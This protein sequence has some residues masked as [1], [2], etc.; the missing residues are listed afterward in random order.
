MNLL[1]LDRFLLPA[2]LAFSVAS[3]V[4]ADEFPQSY[5]RN[6]LTQ[7]ATEVSVDTSHLK[8]GEFMSIRY[9]GRPVYIYRR[10]ASDIKS[11]ESAQEKQFADPD[12][13]GFRASVLREYGSSS[14]AVWARLLFLAQ[15]IAMKRRFRSINQEFAVIGGWSPESGCSLAFVEVKNRIAPGVIFKDPCSGAQFDAA[16][17]AFSTASI[18]PLM[19]RQTSSNVAIP[20]Y[21]VEK[22]GKISFGITPGTTIPELNFTREELY[23]NLDSTMLLLTAARYND[24]DTVRAALKQGA[25]ANFYKAGV[26][27]PIDAAVVGSSM[28]VIKLLVDHGA[29][30]TPKTL[31]GAKFVGRQDVIAYLESMPD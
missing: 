21:H 25:D 18:I 9:V 23:G 6:Q 28:E 20:P 3:N 27:S 12:D 31:N 4:F 19:E 8:A 13:S 17:K 16:G 10:T 11:L 1:R 30:K 24:M 22:N 5:I 14:S 26:G 15:P 29:K 2:L 7:A